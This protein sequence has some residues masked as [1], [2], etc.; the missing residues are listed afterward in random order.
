MVALFRSID[1]ET[2]LLHMLLLEYLYDPR[3]EYVNGYPEF[4]HLITMF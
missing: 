1:F 3:P 2:S 4:R